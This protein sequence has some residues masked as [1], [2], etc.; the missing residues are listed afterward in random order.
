M[1]VESWNAVCTPML[2]LVAPGPRVTK[3]TPGRPVSLPCASAMKAAPPSCRQMTNRMRSRCCMKAVQHRQIAFARHA[4]GMGHALGHQA[5]DEQMAGV[6][7][8]RLGHLD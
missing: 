5:F 6:P 7:R 3:H 1:G 4:K 2:A 8:H